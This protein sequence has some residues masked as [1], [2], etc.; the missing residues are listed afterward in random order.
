MKADLSK[1]QA[2]SKPDSIVSRL[3]R[4]RTRLRKIFVR[5]KREPIARY[6]ALLRGYICWIDEPVNWRRVTRRFRLSGWCFSQDGNKIEGLRAR[7][8]D[9]EFIVSHGLARPDVAAAYRDQAGAL[10]SGFEVVVQAPRGAVHSLRFEAH[11]SEGLWRQGLFRHRQ[12]GTPG[13]RADVAA[14]GR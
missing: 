13:R 1:D 8:G 3:E 2:G 11:H 5:T 9:R 4:T 7:L 14:H 10:Q 12:T 6:E